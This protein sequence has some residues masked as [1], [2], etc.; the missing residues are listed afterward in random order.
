M[1]HVYEI[2]GREVMDPHMQFEFDIENNKIV[3]F[4]FNNPIVGLEY[5]LHNGTDPEFE[6]E[7]YDYAIQWLGN[8]KQKG[9]YIESEQIYKD[10]T[11]IGVYFYDYDKDHNIIYTNNPSISQEQQDETPLPLEK[12][13]YQILDEH[14]GAGTP[15]ERYRNN[16]AA[17]RLLF[18]WKKKE[19]WQR[20]KNRISL[21]NTLAGVVYP[22]PLTN[23]N[24]TGLMN[25]M[26]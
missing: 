3:P 15:K 24:P 10:E 9:Y 1:Y 23:Q 18:L 20:R 6:T 19:D 17:I 4:Y 2:E 22:K 25:I 13:N 12:I 5:D 14:L 16:I 8:I 11:K 21:R 26:N 7:L